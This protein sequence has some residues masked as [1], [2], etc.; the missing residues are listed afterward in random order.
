MRTAIKTAMDQAGSVVV[1]RSR[2]ATLVWLDGIPVLTGEPLP[3][4]DWERRV[5]DERDERMHRGRGFG[6]MTESVLG[7]ASA[8]PSR[9]FT[10]RGRSGAVR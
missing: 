8:H 3:G 10:R 7:G 1:P 2:D 5:E 4:V 9:R 6:A